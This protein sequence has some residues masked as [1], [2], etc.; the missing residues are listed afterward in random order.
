MAFCYCKYHHTSPACL[1]CIH[2]KPFAVSNMYTLHI[3][4]MRMVRSPC[5]F[6]FLSYCDY[7]SYA[8]LFG[9]TQTVLAGKLTF[10]LWLIRPRRPWSDA[11]NPGLTTGK[12]H[13]GRSLETPQRDLASSVSCSPAVNMNAHVATAHSHTGLHRHLHKGC[14]YTFIHRHTHSQTHTRTTSWVPGANRGQS[15]HCVL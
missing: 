10:F 5:F 3:I 15:G 6:F 8:E 2:P 7:T 4:S 1:Y 11:I 14:A 12:E 9:S 13:Y